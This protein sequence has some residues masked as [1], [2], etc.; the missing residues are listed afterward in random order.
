MTRAALTALNVAGYLALCG[1]HLTVTIILNLTQQDPDYNQ[2]L[3]VSSVAMS[4]LS[5]EFS[6]NRLEL[7]CAI[8]LTN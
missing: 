1:L 3:I 7:F 5:T 8:L 2:T 4:H 6:E